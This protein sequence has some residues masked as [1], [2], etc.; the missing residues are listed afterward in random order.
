MDNDDNYMLTLF[1]KIDHDTIID[2]LFN[3]ENNATSKHNI[4]NNYNENI[5]NEIIIFLKHKNRIIHGNYAFGLLLNKFNSGNHY[6]VHNINFYT[7]TPINDII[8]LCNILNKKNIKYLN[9]R[10]TMTKGTYALYGNFIE[11]CNAVYMPDNIF[12]ICPTI[13]TFDILICDPWL[14]LVDLQSIIISPINNHDK[15]L[16]NYNHILSL[17]KLNIFKY[18]ESS[19]HKPLIISNDDIH[20]TNIIENI[21]P[22]IISKFNCVFTGQL[23]YLFYTTSNNSNDFKISQ[24]ELITDGS[25]NNILISLKDILKI[26]SLDEHC[27]I[28]C[29]NPLLNY[30]NNRIIVFY[31]N[32][33]LIN[34]LIAKQKNIPYIETPI[35]INHKNI[36]FKIS[37]F[38]LTV[39]YFLINYLYRQ[40]YEPDYIASNMDYVFSLFTS[41]NNYLSKNIKSVLD[42]T[43]YIN[44]TDTYLN[45]NII[46]ITKEIKYN[47]IHL[48]GKFFYEPSNVTS[49]K[50]SNESNNVK[51]YNDNNN[52][53]LI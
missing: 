44:D 22:S 42:N 29:Y 47:D 41:R 34:L 45:M 25:I 27:S 9:C 43:I 11:Y 20:I 15:L 38:I 23:A 52:A 46:E 35:N 7:P 21:L 36:N 18:P 48:N 32:K 24:I 17:D 49:N 40:L 10:E 31:K 33:E 26:N 50:S 12:S 53:K 8:E 1:S 28:K 13:N 39:N 2:N 37:S 3:I 19:K 6:E 51:E 5:F 4:Q 30:W 14:L 16:K